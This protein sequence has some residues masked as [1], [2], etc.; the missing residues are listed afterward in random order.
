MAKRAHKVR[1]SDLELDRARA[2]AREFEAADARVVRAEYEAKMDSLKLSFSD[3]LIVSIPRNH[4]QGLEGANRSELSNIELVG[5]GT[6][7]HW[8]RL[9]VDH[10][11]FGLLQHRFGTRRWI[12]EIGRRGGRSRSKAKAKAARRNGRAGGRPRTKTTQ[13]SSRQ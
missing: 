1:L 9:D 10:Y 6:G 13:I 2:Q 8:P 11:V 12:S 3:G 5:H 4:L 7:L